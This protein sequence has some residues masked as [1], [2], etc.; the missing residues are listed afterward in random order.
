MG[1]SI[2][3]ALTLAGIT[4]TIVETDAAGVSRANSNL[5]ALRRQTAARG[6][7]LPPSPRTVAGYDALPD[8]DIAIEA[9][10][11]DLGVKQAIFAQL[12]ASLPESTALA[13]NTSYLDVNRIA[14]G[15]PHPDRLLGLHFFSPAHIMRLVEI[16]R[17]DATSDDTLALA[18]GLAAQL[19]KIPVA[20]GICDGFIGNRILTRYRQST[21]I[22]LLEGALPWQVDRAMQDFGMAMGPYA[23]QDLSGL[24]IAYANR[25]RLKLRDD[26]AHRYIPVAD[27]LVEG[28]QR[29]GRKTG[30]GWYDYPDG[31]P[32]PSPV[33]TGIIEAASAEA[34]LMRRV[35]SATE[36]QDRALTAMVDEA[37]R[38]LDEGIAARP[39]DIDLV[40][41]HGYAF[42]RWR[43]GLMHY[44]DGVG[45]NVFLDR[46]RRWGDEDPRSWSEGPLMARL[47]AEG[48]SL[49]DL[50]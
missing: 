22:L 43:G 39:S 36:I 2:A 49:A 32:V 34:G 31:K 26:P 33:V 38:I 3:H 6:V 24:D 9:A 37:C 8:A 1:A 4:V 7:T 42:P 45:L 25:Q 18:H 41:V 17:A 28:L 13:T 16:I 44:A 14:E 46:V 40:M 20:A 11:E 19:G 12:A 48:C 35:F 23:V 47:V 50:N 30:A 27:R 5:D 15:I 21:D 29:L 10:F